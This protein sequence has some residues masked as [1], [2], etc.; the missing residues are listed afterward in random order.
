[1]ETIRKHALFNVLL[2]GVSNILY[3][4]SF[5]LA[6]EP[7]TDRHTPPPKETHS[8]AVTAPPAKGMGWTSQGKN[9]ANI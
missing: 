2:F 4:L 1:M 5:S 8:A 9:Q 6:Y 7:K 3:G